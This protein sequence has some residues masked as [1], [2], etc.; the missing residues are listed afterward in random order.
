M[1]NLIKITKKVNK[2]TGKTEY[3]YKEVN[4]INIHSSVLDVTSFKEVYAR[5][6]SKS[7]YARLMVKDFNSNGNFSIDYSLMSN[8]DTPFIASK[9]IIEDISNPFTGNLITDEGKNDD[10]KILFYTV[11]KSDPKA[12]ENIYIAVEGNKWYEFNGGNVS[13]NEN[14]E[15]LDIG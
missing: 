12:N 10:D 5:E 6:I 13:D 9:D 14:Y 7:R 4:D 11:D 8:A 2:D 1:L 3:G 15:E